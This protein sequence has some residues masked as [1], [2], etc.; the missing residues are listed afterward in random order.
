M[1]LLVCGGRH[2]AD[3][4]FVFSVLDRVDARR[5][6]MLLIHGA[7]PGADQLADEWAASRGVAR[8]PNPARWKELGRPAGPVRNQEMLDIFAPDGA[9]A[10]PGNDGTADMVARCRA[11]GVLVW[12]PPYP[13]SGA[14][15]A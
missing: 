3:R 8:A 7:A 1:K 10:F 13:L 15:P 14:A 12:V 11:A 2:F 6:V 4:A 9:V 5:Q